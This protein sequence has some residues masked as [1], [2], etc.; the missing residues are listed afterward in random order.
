MKKILILLLLLMVVIPS[1]LQAQ[2]LGTSV[3][4]KFYVGAKGAYGISSFEP[5]ITTVSKFGEMTFD[6]ISYGILFGFNLTGNIGIQAEVNY[7]GYGADNIDRTYLYSPQ[8]PAL[9][10]YGE[11]SVV[12]HL[13]LDLNYIDIPLMVKLTLSKIGFSPYLYAGVNWGI[14][15]QGNTTIVRKISATEAVYREY[16]DDITD[17]ILYNELAPVGGIGAK[18]N[19]GSLSLLID[20]RYKHGFMNVSNIDNNLG[21]KNRTLWGSLGLVYNL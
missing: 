10:P 9:Q 21:F 11:F 15:V 18:W 14:N 7:A 2:D 5:V 8:S 12:D 6:N 4:S 16:K 1:A 20:V 13:D 19:F 3:D 17:R